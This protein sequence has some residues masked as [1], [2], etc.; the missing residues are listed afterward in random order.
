MIA[1][2]VVLQMTAEGA[3]TNRNERDSKPVQVGRGISAGFRCQSYRV[4]IEGDGRCIAKRG[5]KRKGIT[6]PRN[7]IDKSSVHS[8]AQMVSMSG[9]IAC[10]DQ[11]EALANAIRVQ[12]VSLEWINLAAVMGND[13]YNKPTTVWRLRHRDGHIRPLGR[14][15]A[16][17]QRN[18][19][20]VPRRHA[21]ARIRLRRVA[22]RFTGWNRHGQNFLQMDGRSRP[23]SFSNFMAGNRSP[24]PICGGI[25]LDTAFSWNAISCPVSPTNGRPYL[26]IATFS[27]PDADK[28]VLTLSPVL[29][30][31]VVLDARQ[32]SDIPVDSG[33]HL[34]RGCVRTGAAHGLA[35]PVLVASTSTTRSS[36]GRS[37]R[38]HLP[39]SCP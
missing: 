5:H 20:L 11:F 12:A 32:N 35:V 39:P 38:D 36:L 28:R 33:K 3:A 25:L 7:S 37:T 10:A 19:G 9:R 24:S 17:H 8:F 18:G 27:L 21:P 34:I 31:H 1:V 29:R 30:I 6:S 4:Q 2:S 23:N 16:Q 14:C 22:Q 15:S 26:P 13:S